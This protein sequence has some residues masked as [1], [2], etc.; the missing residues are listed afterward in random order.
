MDDT[1]EGEIGQNELDT[2][3]DTI[4]A[5][6]NFKCLRL[7]GMVC[8][9]HGFHQSFRAIPDVPVATVATAWDDPMTGITYILIIN[10]ALYFGAQL[11][12]S[13]INVNQIRV[14]GLS[15][16]DDPYD[17]YRQLGIDTMD[18]HIPFELEGNTVYF[19]SRVPSQ[20]ELEN[21]PY[22]ILTEDT[23]WDPK[24]VDLTDP[25]PKEIGQVTISETCSAERRIEENLAYRL[26]AKVNVV[27]EIV[28]RTRH[29]AVSP[30]HIAQK[31][32]IGI[33]KAKDTLR[34]TTQKGIR[35]AIHPIH[36]RYRVDHLLHL[37]INA[38]QIMQ[39]IY[40][41]HMQSKVRSLGKNAGVFLY[42][43]GA[44]TKVYPVDSTS[45]AGET[46]VDFT[47]DVGI[48][49]DIRTDL[50]SY[51]TGKETSFVKEA[52]RLRIK[53]TY[54]EKGRHIQ[55]HA[56]ERE[57]RDIKRRWHAKMIAKRIPKR[58]WDYG[59]VHQA[60]LMSRMARGK[61][62]RT[63]YEE[64][65]GE[66]PDISEWLD[67][68]M[69]DL[70]WYHD[71]PGTMSEMTSE[72]KKLGRWLGVANRVGSALTYWVLTQACKVI[73]RSTIQ[74]VTFD[75]QVDTNL[76]TSIQEFDRAVNECLDNKTHECTN[77]LAEGNILQDEDNLFNDP[78]YGNGDNT[79][80]DEEYRMETLPPEREEEDDLDA[81]AYDKFIG[82]EVTVDFGT[83]GQKRATVKSRA[84]DF[85]GK[86]LGQHSANPELDHREYE[87][88]YE[89]GT[90]DRMFANQIAA[91]LFSQVDD[92]GNRHLLLKELTDHQS[93][94]TAIRKENGYDISKYG[95]K[96]RKKT[97]RG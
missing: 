7:T 8:Q 12:H 89:D 40:V 67:F 72:I 75:E 1:K 41:D 86:P 46:L 79:P 34:A 42:T 84:C 13:L 28:S 87:I 93:D 94:Q 21:S 83:E 11:D 14:T 76:Q 90:C 52:R 25:R 26:Q 18:V 24:T 66:T 82:A 78:A 53:I 88:E 69:Y 62:G 5:G 50:A 81:E 54:A 38:R 65:V 74:H 30:E 16:C 6:R 58:L 43:T 64:V 39:Q 56:A 19:S 97:T 15:V 10:Q 32:N 71:P 57:I 2:R 70:I 17:R 96:T 9:V 95:I 91:N 20:Y 60:E 61:H 49:T 36:K 48:P 27:K 63:G 3:A 31:W 23:E 33:E 44:F 92:D 68:D 4:C 22:I 80:T 73:A 47:R 35:Y 77:L 45:K 37:G 55:N 29:S 85:D 59:V 51:F